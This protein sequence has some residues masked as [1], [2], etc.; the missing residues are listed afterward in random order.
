MFSF[1][2]FLVFFFVFVS[3]AAKCVVFDTLSMS[4]F[5]CLPPMHF[6][7]LFQCICYVYFLCKK[8][9]EKKRKKM[10]N[11]HAQFVNFTSFNISSSK[12]NVSLKTKT[13]CVDG[14]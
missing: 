12:R 11:S 7:V 13:I 1:F 14:S 6:N 9:K 5:L 10:I 4:F 8:K 3:Y 2:S